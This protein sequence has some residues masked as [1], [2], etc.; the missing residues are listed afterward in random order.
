MAYPLTTDD[1]I[2]RFRSDVDDPIR[3]TGTNPDAANLWKI[4]DV[5]DYMS[6]AAAQVGRKTEVLFKTFTL[7][8]VAGQPLVRLPTG[9]MVLDIRLVH[10]ASPRRDL[11]EVN[12][13]EGRRPDFRD[14]N[15]YLYGNVNDW[16]ELQGVP[17]AYT[18]NYTPGYLRI[19]PIPTITTTI[20][21][22]A[23]LVPVLLDGMPLPFTDI[24]DIELMLL[25]MKKLAYSKHDA[26]TFD[27]TRAEGYDREFNARVLARASEARRVR[28]APQP[29]TFQW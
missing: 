4:T 23:M 1:L 22:T 2:R 27:P 29:I 11:E 18:R 20:D 8:I 13:E 3:G 24:E 6:S 17:R 26:D 10:M 19:I 9:S 5:S 12:I 14:Y 7:P 25:W 16:E 28:R 15:S 21:V